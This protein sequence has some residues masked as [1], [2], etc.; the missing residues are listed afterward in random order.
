MEKFSISTILR[1]P[2]RG[3]HESIKYGPIRVL[4]FNR[5]LDH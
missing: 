5:D 3:T 1:T 2:N 4:F